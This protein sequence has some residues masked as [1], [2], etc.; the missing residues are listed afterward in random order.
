MVLSTMLRESVSSRNAAALIRERNSRLLGGKMRLC[1]I[2][3]PF[4]V[5]VFTLL[6]AGAASANTVQLQYVKGTPSGI[7]GG[8]VYPYYI[9]VNNSKSYTYLMC[10]SFDNTVQQG[11]TWTATVSP[12]LQ[13]IASSMFGPSMTLDYKAAGLIF[14]ALISGT[15]TSNV[16][17]QWAI[18]GLFSSNARGQSQFTT[19][20]AAAIDS[21]YLGKALTDPNSAYKGLLLYT[22]IAG[23]QSW[24]GI[25]Q[26]FLGYS[27]VPEPSSLMLM[28]TGLIGLAEAIRR[29]FAKP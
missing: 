28:G 26:E 6:V 13:G 15:I 10:D 20:G 9:H 29:K 5:L 12:L 11:E 1:H 22:P 8:A 3:V 21:F 7:G 27:A 17:A 16:D 19:T 23:T 14:K 2:R 24:G 18:W 25:P 4:S